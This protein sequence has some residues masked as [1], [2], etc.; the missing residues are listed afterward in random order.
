[1][2]LKWVNYRSKLSSAVLFLEY[3]VQATDPA[4]PS[5]P[6]SLLCLPLRLLVGQGLELAAITGD[7]QLGPDGLREGQELLQGFDHDDRPTDLGQ[8]AGAGDVGLADR[9]LRRVRSVGVRG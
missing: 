7:V 6:P 5:L 8:E 4:P 3:F 9:G 1:M 2:C